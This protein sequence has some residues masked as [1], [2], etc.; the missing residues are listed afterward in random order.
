[1][2]STGIKPRETIQTVMGHI[3]RLESAQQATADAVFQLRELMGRA[4]F[5][6]DEI[7]DRTAEVDLKA[8]DK[9]TRLV[10]L[11]EMIIVGVVYSAVI[12]A[13]YVWMI[14]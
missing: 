1:M 8:H 12:G 11:K 14:S 7:P 6:E 3:S 10:M 4:P 2:K 5:E 13:A 9:E